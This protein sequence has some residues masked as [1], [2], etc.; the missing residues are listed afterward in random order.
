MIISGRCLGRT[1]SFTTGANTVNANAGLLMNNGTVNINGGTMN[2]SG[3][4][5]I[6]NGIAATL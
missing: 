2:V 1:D 3:G 6:G 5:F 4:V